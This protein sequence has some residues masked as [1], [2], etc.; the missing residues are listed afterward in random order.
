MKLYFYILEDNK[1][2]F[3]ECEVEEK[4]KSYTL[5]DHIY[6]FYGSRVLKSEI[7]LKCEYN[8]K[9]IVILENQDDELAKKYFCDYLNE[10]IADKQ[11]EIEGL[12]E[13][14]KVVNDWNT[15]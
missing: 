6:G 12:Q 7:G 5:K 10:K 4:P 3:S 8:W 14:M 9:Q 2:R 13:K 1:I 15:D 11:K